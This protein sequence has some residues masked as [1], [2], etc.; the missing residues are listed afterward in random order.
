MRRMGFMDQP[1]LLQWNFCCVAPRSSFGNSYRHFRRFTIEL[2][3]FK[4]ERMNYL[5]LSQNN[6]LHKIGKS[7]LIY[8]QVTKN[9]MR[10]TLYFFIFLLT[11]C[12]DRQSLS[13]KILNDSSQKKNE[14]AIAK[15]EQDTA[16]SNDQIFALIREYPL[17]KDTANFI[18]QL[19][20]NGNLEPCFLP[21][22]PEVKESITYYKKIKLNGSNH[23]YILCEYN[24]EYGCNA[25]FPWK[26]QLFFTPNGKLI[27]VL[28]AFR[29]E[30][31][32]VFSNQKPFLLTVVSTARGN[33][34]HQ[35]FKIS[36][37]TLENVYEGYTDFQTKTY[38]ACEDEAV[39]E[40][41]E[42]KVS[43]KDFNGDGYNDLAFNGKLVLIMGMTKDSMWYDI[44]VRGKDATSYSID[45]PFKKLPIQYVYL[46]NSTTGHF[47]ESKKFSKKYKIE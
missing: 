12:S 22:G 9:C 20:K 25:D 4:V 10:P 3:H 44:H 18:Q 21:V 37:D 6:F 24:Y 28:S 13:Q 14:N 23:D 36:A 41:N 19:K 11:D 5:N 15:I 47:V 42:L 32:K 43:L 31:L 29:F 40:P 7:S 38:D 27:N 46:Y 26:H 35:L 30:L 16:K 39:Y 33:G 17:I 34:G 2:N 1:P 45:H 8:L